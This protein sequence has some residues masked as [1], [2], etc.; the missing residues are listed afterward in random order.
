MAE[1]RE[2]KTFKFALQEHDERGTFKGYASVFGVVDSYRDVVDAGAFKKSLKDNKHFPMLWSHD[3]YEPIGIVMGE[4]DEKGLRIEGHYNMDVPRAV[5]TRSLA[6]QGAVNGLSIGFT[7]VREAYDKDANV[8]HLRE[9]KLY[10]IS[11]C[12]FQACPG[13]LIAATKMSDLEQKPYPN[14]HA[15]RIQ[16]P[17]KYDDFRRAK[18]GKVWGKDIPETVGVIWGHPK[19]SESGDWE[20]QALRFPTSAWTAA[21]ARAWLKANDIKYIAFEPAAKSLEGIA[22]ELLGLRARGSVTPQEKTLLRQAAADIVA[23]LDGDGPGEPP[24]AGGS[25]EQ[26]DRAAICTLLD[27]LRGGYEQL[28]QKI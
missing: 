10:E 5:Q 16:S 21:E 8:R 25:R 23:L 14:E 9:V 4:E 18:D 24:A 20:P 26:K 13:A 12:V 7:T 11:P 22:E 1:M 3:Q 27:G 28:R 19:G 17:D 2:E 6:I 15:A